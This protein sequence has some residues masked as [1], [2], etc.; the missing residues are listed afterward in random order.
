MEFKQKTCFSTIIPVLT[1]CVLNVNV[2][3]AST[4]DISFT[5]QV[6]AQTPGP[7]AAG[8]AVDLKISD[9]A[10]PDVLQFSISTALVG[11]Q[12]LN[13]IYLDLPTAETA[14]LTGIS[15]SNSTI[16][17]APLV[18]TSS[19]VNNPQTGSEWA[20]TQLLVPNSSTGAITGLNDLLISFAVGSITGPTGKGVATE[21]FDLTFKGTTVTAADFLGLTTGTGKY[22]GFA[23]IALESGAASSG[24][25]VLG[26]LTVPVPGAVWLFGS[27]L[28]GF[29]GFKRRKSS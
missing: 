25:G 28:A 9:T 12:E 4:V 20:A 15:I 27:A 8:T 29:M 10:T 5:K 2:A 19:T 21:T 7:F 26:G 11:S 14:A 1:V 3:Q 24:T 18:F 17:G 6:A 16:A 13:K 22:N 23:Q